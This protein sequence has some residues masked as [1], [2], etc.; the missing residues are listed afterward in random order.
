MPFARERE[1]RQADRCTASDVR[2]AT[3]AAAKT[4]GLLSLPRPLD[5]PSSCWRSGLRGPSVCPAVQAGSQP[6][7]IILDLC[8][9]ALLN[10]EIARPQCH[11]LYGWLLLLKT[12]GLD[13][14]PEAS[15]STRQLADG[16]GTFD[17]VLAT[18]PQNPAR[19]YCKS[20]ANLLTTGCDDPTRNLV[21]EYRVLPFVSD[22]REE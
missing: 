21:I 2:M 5:S 3:S 16:E 1:T 6:Q 18:H 20:S 7:P 8:R 14:M 13:C 11:R 10:Q 12:S 22:A 15:S 19:H 17:V 4:L 9:N